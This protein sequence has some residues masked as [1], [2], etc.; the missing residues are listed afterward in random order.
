MISVF[1]RLE[2]D[3]HLSG[4]GAVRC[5]G[6]RHESLLAFSCKCRYFCPSCHAKRLALWSPWLE[7]T[8]LA[9]AYYQRAEG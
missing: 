3:V 6:W 1:V 5:G 8:R 7:E 9:P 4:G 2:L